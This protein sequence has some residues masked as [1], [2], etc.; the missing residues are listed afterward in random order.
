MSRQPTPWTVLALTMATLLAAGAAHAWKPKTHL[1]LAEQA[2][3]DAV[4]DGR[5]SLRRVDFWSGAD[6]GPL[7]DF[8]VDPE[9]LAA[10]RDH[11]A[12][13][14]AGIVGPDGYPDVVTGQLGV[15]P[16]THNG[17]GGTDGWLQHL[18]GAG[19]SG[20]RR[21]LAFVVGFL[22][23]AAGDLTAHTMVNR[24]AGGEFTYDPPENAQTHI[25]LESYI[26]QHTPPLERL[27]LN[28]AQGESVLSIA[29]L[30]RFLH[31]ELVDSRAPRGNGVPPNP[32][33]AQLLGEA[34]GSTW[35]SIMSALRDDLESFIAGY[36]QRVRELR[37]EIRR[38]GLFEEIYLR[39]VLAVY[40]AAVGP[41][42]SYAE[43][44]V[45]DIRVGLLVWPAVSHDVAKL[46]MLGPPHTDLHGAADRL[47][48]YMFDHGY[49]MLG[50]PDAVGDILEV[51]DFVGDMLARVLRVELLEA[52]KRAFFDFLL[53][54]AFGMGIDE[55]ESML[56][57][58]ET[59]MQ[60]LDALRENRAEIDAALGL[61]GGRTEV[62]FE[63]FPAGYNTI[64]L[65]KTSFLSEAARARLARLLGCVG[66]CPIQRDARNP[67]LGYIRSIDA[68]NQWNAHAERMPL[69]RD[70]FLYTQI[71]KHQIGEHHDAAAGEYRE[72]EAGARVCPRLHDV[73]LLPVGNGG[74]DFCG[75][76]GA[77]DVDVSLDRPAQEAGGVVALDGTVTRQSNPQAVEDWP[78][79][80]DFAWVS[81]FARG[82]RLRASVPAGLERVGRAQLAVD[83]ERL[84]SAR[85]TVEV[86]PPALSNLNIPLASRDV[87]NGQPIRGHVEIDCPAPEWATTVELRSQAFA[88]PVLVHIPAG[89]SRGDFEV[90]T[91]CVASDRA[92]DVTATYLGAEITTQVTVR[93]AGVKSMTLDPTQVAGL[94]ARTDVTLELC[95]GSAFYYYRW[96][97]LT[98]GPMV[99]QT[100]APNDY[101]SRWLLLRNGLARHTFP[102]FVQS[103]P[104]RRGAFVATI[105]ASSWPDMRSVAA[106]LVVEVGD[107]GGQLPECF[108]D[109]RCDQVPRW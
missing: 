11:P 83:A 72:G 99:G 42:V 86:R 66:D 40:R 85:D 78:T 20:D 22:G 81:P 84:A 52:I 67:L 63:A 87:V 74:G 109:P 47:E 34:D 106:D 105:G 27:G 3:Q 97:L 57:D 43:A 38:A 64:T 59:W 45:D 54:Q 91:V 16:D 80:P 92:I 82:V 94:G 5:V 35:P 32:R 100:P 71:F 69:A 9:I 37:R 1:Y 39:I 13:Y 14:R 61:V 68:S 30:E 60:E 58:P 19:R 10:L 88:G 102:M 18:W 73:T 76:G 12:H 26:E 79:V 101:E 93:A 70:C 6:L 108:G 7:G 41:L 49:S 8:E 48:A 51:A 28:P 50:A 36:Y 33:L 62:D 46:V 4:D 96:V 77:V 90:P 23:H 56:T 17:A 75:R 29:G 103:V 31:D 21:R 65:L 55:L 95:P 15:H 107:N 98:Y 44:W 53:R 104:A 89:A 2:R 24:Y 25:V